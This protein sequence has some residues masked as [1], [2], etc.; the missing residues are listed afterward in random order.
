MEN[1]KVFPLSSEVCLNNCQGRVYLGLSN[2]FAYEETCQ[3]EVLEKKKRNKSVDPP[4]FFEFRFIRSFGSSE[5]EGKRPRR[6]LGYGR[7]HSISSSTDSLNSE[8]TELSSSQFEPEREMTHK[9]CC[10]C[11]L[12]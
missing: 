2:S 3:S 4:S 11:V 5:E 10:L 8:I 12:L 9:S 6:S 1:R 7:K